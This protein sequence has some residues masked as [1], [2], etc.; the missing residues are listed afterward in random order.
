MIENKRTSLGGPT[1]DKEGIDENHPWVTD[2][3]GTFAHDL[4]RKG[5]ICP[6]ITC[7]ILIYCGSCI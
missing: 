3:E 7:K 2:D 5:T 6:Y 1:G 4:V